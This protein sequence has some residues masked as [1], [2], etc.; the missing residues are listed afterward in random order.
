MN[1]RC[2]SQ[3]CVGI[4]FLLSAVVSG[5]SSFE[6]F[7]SGYGIITTIAGSGV[8]DNDDANLWIPAYE[9][10]AAVSAQLSG[11]HMAMADSAGNVFIADKDANAIRKVDPAGIITT[12]A[13]TNVAA[14]GGEGR[15]TEVPLDHPNGV[16]VNRQG[17]FYILDLNNN[18]IRRVDTEGNMTTVIHDPDGISL[19]RGLWVSAQEDTIWYASGTHIHQWTA[20]G[21]NSVFADGFSALGNIVQ[22]RNG[23]LV[24]TD[25]SA[26]RVYRMDRNGA[27]TVIAGNGSSD[28]G[29]EGMAAMETPL[30]GV[31]G[32]WFLADNSYFLAP[33]EGSNIWYVDV[34]GIAHRFLAGREGDEYHSGDNESFRT[35]GDKISEARAVT[36]DYGGN[37]IV[38]ENDR[39]F[40][41]KIAKT[42]SV[43]RRKRP[44]AANVSRRT[45]LSNLPCDITVVRLASVTFGE[46]SV[47]VHDEKGRC[48]NVAPMSHVVDG[49]TEIS[50]RN[51]DLPSGCYVFNILERGVALS[52]GRFIVVR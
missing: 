50:W 47:T 24:A 45:R 48:M 26:N 11:P 18:K 38:T 20:A 21:G 27:K 6:L 22:D 14:D 35:P 30:H 3:W 1:I 7:C 15:A 42:T 5:S 23:F 29:V 40:V 10:G 31:R 8:E 12:V 17:G 4:T 43:E 25:R 19:G 13:G 44:G 28:E 36:V 2:L 33:H 9:G 51:T 39:G 37:V 16:W 49:C 41:R 34:T 52:G 46:I 32:V